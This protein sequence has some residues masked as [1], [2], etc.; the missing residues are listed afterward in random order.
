MRNFTDKLHQPS[1]SEILCN[2]S[3]DAKDRLTIE[4]MKTLHS[5]FKNDEYTSFQPCYTHFS[6]DF[7]LHSFAVFTIYCVKN[8]EL[9]V[10]ILTEQLYRR[11]HPGD[12]NLTL[13]CLIYW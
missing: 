9:F 10:I 13:I 3:G 8:Q 6:E 5:S 12:S 7:D 4:T 2:V 1:G 11:G